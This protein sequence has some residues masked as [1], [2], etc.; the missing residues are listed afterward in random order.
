MG[1][2]TSSR[3]LPAFFGRTQ[4]YYALIKKALYDFHRLLQNVRAYEVNVI[5]YEKVFYFIDW[6]LENG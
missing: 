1:E 5:I 3:F 2:V 6:L 4:N